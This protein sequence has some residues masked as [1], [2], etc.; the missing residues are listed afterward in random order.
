VLDEPHAI[1]PVAVISDCYRDA[2][3]LCVAQLDAESHPLVEPDR[4]LVH[5]G[6]HRADHASAPCPGDGE[7]MLVE[8]PAQPAAALCRVDADEMDISLA[9]A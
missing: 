9:R 6:R 3:D 8:L 5:R 1:L 7:E 2:I 4:A